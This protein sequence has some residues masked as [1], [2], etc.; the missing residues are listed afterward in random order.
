MYGTKMYLHNHFSTNIELD[1]RQHTN[2]NE[3]N[4]NDF[5][6]DTQKLIRFNGNKRNEKFCYGL[7]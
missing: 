6:S 1:E 7:F 2:S 4:K 5:P 3:R